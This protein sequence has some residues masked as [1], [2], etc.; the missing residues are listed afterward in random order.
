[1]EDFLVDFFDGSAA[2]G[3]RLGGRDVLNWRGYGVGGG[4]FGWF[5]WRFFRKGW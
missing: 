5:L 4:C 1:M 2:V 3:T